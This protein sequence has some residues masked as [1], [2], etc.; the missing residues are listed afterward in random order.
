MKGGVIYYMPSFLYNTC[1]FAL[2]V[3]QIKRMLDKE[4]TAF[5]KMV[6]S[7][8]KRQTAKKPSHRLMKKYMYQMKVIGGQPCYIVRTQN[9]NT[10][11]AVLF[12]FG[13]GYIMP[14]DQGDFSF[15]GEIAKCTGADVYLPM[16]PLAPRYKLND[17]VRSVTDVYQEILQHYEAHNIIFMG[18]SSGAAFCLS[19]CLFILHERLSI[20]FPG[21]LIMM[22]PGFQMPPS[23]EQ[24][25]RMR[26]QEKT[27]IMIPISF[28]RNISQVLINEDSAYLLNAFGTSWERFPEMDIYYG[29]RELFYAYI[30]DIEKAAREGNVS[31]HIHIGENMMHCWPMLGFTREVKNT[32]TEIYR[33]IQSL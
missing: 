18:N 20:P 19:I 28:C 13:G 27:D 1:S 15:A 26:N 10:D 31:V 3:I 7:F 29:D 11:K 2:H 12:L 6:Q 8:E 5:D 33:I 14:P 9:S 25:K 17:T 16:Y 24:I 30:P 23:E 32:R 21:R 22:S 4:S